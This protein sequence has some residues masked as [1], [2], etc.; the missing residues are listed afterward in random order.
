MIKTRELRVRSL[1]AGLQGPID[2]LN[3]IKI[4][5]PADPKYRPKK[6]YVEERPRLE[7]FRGTL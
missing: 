4:A 2:G 7:G 5:V 3:S 6:E 1:H